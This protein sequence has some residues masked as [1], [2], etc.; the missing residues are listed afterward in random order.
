MPT[1]K[2]LPSGSYRVKVYDHSEHGK[3]IYQSFT[4]PTKDE[5]E[6]QAAE[7]KRKKNR[8][9]KFDMTI[10][11]CLN[12]YISA[13]EN[14]LSPS[15]VRGYLRMVKN[16]FESIKNIRINKITSET[17]QIFVSELAKDKSPKTVR[18]IYGLLVSA[19]GL[20]LPDMTFRVTLP[21]KCIKKEF[22]PS[23]EDVSALYERATKELKKCIA[24]AAFGSLRRGEICALTFA[25]L[26]GNTLSITKDMIQRKDNK[27][28]VKDIPKTAASAR[29]VRLPKK[30]I[31]LL[32]TGESNERII[33]YK[34]PGSITQCFTK[35]RDRMGIN[36][37]FHQ[38]RK[39]YASIGVVLGIPDTYLSDFGGWSK[40][41]NVMKE[42][43]QNNIVSMSDYYSDKMTEYFNKII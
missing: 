5:A 9:A 3:K 31:D 21:Q 29:E 6:Y 19:I 42:V 16:N 15:T 2:R 30:V 23:N 28:I 12:G 20:Y 36:I 39:F 14:V 25:D 8:R 38:L 11:D 34:N 1:A 7:W 43:Y 37:H 32:G 33:K 27:W 13:K 10:E 24:L 4:A 18:N 40:G 41:S 26:K 35:L 17:L 22:S